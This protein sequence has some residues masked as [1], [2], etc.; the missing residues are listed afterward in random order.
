MAERKIFLSDSKLKEE[1][2][3][4]FIFTT[5]HLE[6]SGEQQDFQILCEKPDLG[7]L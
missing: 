5:R 4:L 3:P 1:G 6:N 2:Y 7:L